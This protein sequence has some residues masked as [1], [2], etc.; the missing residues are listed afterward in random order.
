MSTAE[1]VQKLWEH[2]KKFFNVQPR[3]IRVVKSGS[4]HRAFFD[5]GADC[6]FGTTPQEARSRLKALPL[7]A[8]SKL[9]FMGADYGR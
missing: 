5:G 9:K 6:C 1:E 7:I 8:S 3:K 2:N 4:H